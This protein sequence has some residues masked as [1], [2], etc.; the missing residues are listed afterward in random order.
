[1]TSF[2]VVEELPVEPVSRVCCHLSKAAL[3]HSPR[4]HVVGSVVDLVNTDVVSAGR[5]RFT[6]QQD[7]G[8]ATGGSTE[9][10]RVALRQ[11]LNR[12]SSGPEAPQHDNCER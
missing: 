12:K 7:G 4:L 10:F 11:T 1:M 5:W 2:S 9:C 8:T 6:S 3:W